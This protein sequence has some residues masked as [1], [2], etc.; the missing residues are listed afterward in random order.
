MALLKLWQWQ[1]LDRDG[2]AHHGERLASSKNQLQMTLLADA[3]IVLNIKPGRAIG[4]QC[5]HLRQQVMFLRQLAGLLQAGIALTDAI[6]LLAQQHPLAGWRALLSDISRYLRQGESFSRAIEPYQTLFSPLTHAL[7]RAGELTGKMEECCQ[8][9]ANRL[10]QRQQL[11]EKALKALRYPLISLSFGLLVSGVMVGWVLPQFTAIYQSFN[12]PLPAI[13]RG[14]IALSDFCV[15]WGLPITMLIALMGYSGNR[16][17]RHSETLQNRSLLL[18][19]RLPLIAPLLRGYRLS[20]IYTTL[21]LTLHAGI[22]LLEGLDM[23]VKTLPHPMWRAT[24]ARLRDRI[25]AGSLFSAQVSDQRL[26]TP[27]CAMLLR[28]GEE[29]GTLDHML[30]RLSRWHSAQ[31]SQLADGLTALLQPLIMAIVGALIGILLI[32]MYLPVF[33]LGEA[34]SMG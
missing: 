18:L 7:L 16:W 26:F 13:T 24:M 17:F 28:V 21:A 31:A 33:Q 15:R 19:L 22:P 11:T 3:F 25:A 20:Q 14:V 34:M 9:L 30:S 12:A 5:W 32:A 10:E 6:D 4:R 27:V 29:S 1:A 2:F 8:E 23:V